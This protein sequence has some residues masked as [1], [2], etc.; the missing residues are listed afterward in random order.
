MTDLFQLTCANIYFTK[1]KKSKNAFVLSQENVFFTRV[2]N[3]HTQTNNVTL[4]AEVEEGDDNILKHKS[5]L[6]CNWPR[7]FTG[8]KLKLDFT[9][10]Q[11][12]YFILLSTKH[13]NVFSF[14]LLTIDIAVS[15]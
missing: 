4:P 14:F 13:S 11:R 1:E 6:E 15:Q 8:G 9:D 2:H 7:F 5:C 3:M 12:L 10:E